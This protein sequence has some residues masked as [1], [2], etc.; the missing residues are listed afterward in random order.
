[1]VGQPDDNKSGENRSLRVVLQDDLAHSNVNPMRAAQSAMR[2]ALRSRFYQKVEI[3]EA[4][5]GF[6]VLL[7]GRPLRTPAKRVLAAPTRA[8]AQAL[9]TEWDA[10]RPTID[11]ARMPL[12]RLANSIIDGIAEASAAV[13][14][15]VG[16]YLASDLL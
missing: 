12:T 1:M 5:E 6:T 3:G 7:D 14:E 9:A 15:E 8:L 10:Q 2:P 11:P 4:P 13:A 16:R